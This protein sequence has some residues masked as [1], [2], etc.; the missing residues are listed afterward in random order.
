MKR[1]IL[2][3]FLQPDGDHYLLSLSAAYLLVDGFWVAKLMYRTM[4]EL[5]FEFSVKIFQIKE[6][7][8]Q[9]ERMSYIPNHALQWS[10]VHDLF[11]SNLNS[12]F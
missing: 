3:F 11:I 12:R 5:I 2:V 7:L 4:T 8:S 6:R 1:F 10:S 9:K